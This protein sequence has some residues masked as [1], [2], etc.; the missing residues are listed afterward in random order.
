MILCKYLLSF[1]H[2]FLNSINIPSDP[3]SSSGGLLAAFEI[4]SKRL[5][6]I[7]DIPLKVSTV[8]A[9]DSGIIS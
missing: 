3:I 1:I 7:E 6:L 5:R 9:L 4:L 8:H 2:Y